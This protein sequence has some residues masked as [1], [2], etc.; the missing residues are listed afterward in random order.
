MGMEIPLK[1]LEVDEERQRLV[2]SNRKAV[3]EIPTMD[4]KVSAALRRS[5]QYH[6]AWHA[7]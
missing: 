3:T 6:G 2:F 5:Q 4:F 7:H 1:F